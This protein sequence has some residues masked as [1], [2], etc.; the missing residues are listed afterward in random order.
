MNSMTGYGLASRELPQG[1]LTVEVR[2]VNNR[3]LEVNPRLGQ[4]FQ[5][6]DAAV[7]AAVRQACQRGKVDV[8]VRFE[9]TEE[10]QPS[11]RINTA[12][13][14]S[15]YR[16]FSD[17]FPAAEPPR[18]DAVI[19]LPGVLVT[20]G[21][22]RADEELAAGLVATLEDALARMVAERA[23][24]GDALKVVLR[25][26]VA[27]LRA[28]ATS[29]TAARGDVVQ[30]YRERLH[31]RLEELLGPKASSLDPG[32]L[33]MEVALFADKADIAEEC[34]RLA[35]H[36]DAFD[37]ALDSTNPGES[38]G[39]ALEFLSQEILREINTIGSK[40]RDLDIGRHVLLLKQEIEAVREQL[41]NVE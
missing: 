12:L 35:A 3:F 6:A 39:R 9:P 32:R 20:E 16:Q 33:E 17:A 5:N 21:E 24:E 36:L 14:K 37:A 7:R 13:V 38:V 30:K 28:S 8:L 4:A 1:R 11:V 26:H 10:F 15:L 19:A 34:N 29:V 41:A 40:C 2:S 25:A 22:S 18:L 23:R 31:A 27:T